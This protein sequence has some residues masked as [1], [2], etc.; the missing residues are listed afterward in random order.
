MFYLS[1][2]F[3]ALTIAA[4]LALYVYIKLRVD[5]IRDRHVV[6]LMNHDTIFLF[7]QLAVIL[8]LQRF[9]VPH[10]K[11]QYARGKW[12]QTMADGAPSETLPRHSSA[13]GL[14]PPIWPALLRPWLHCARTA[15]AHRTLAWRAH[16]ASETRLRQ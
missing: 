3:A 2:P 8:F 10:A 9:N 12:K 7:E 4:V 16:A 14:T 1:P 15:T 11:E 13:A 5:L 6:L